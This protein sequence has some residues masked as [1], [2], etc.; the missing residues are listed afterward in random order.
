MSVGCSTAV[1]ELLICCYAVCFYSLL[2]TTLL[3]VDTCLTS[4]MQLIQLQLSSLADCAV[5]TTSDTPDW[6]CTVLTGQTWQHEGIVLQAITCLRGC[7]YTSP[8]AELGQLV[9]APAAATKLSALLTKAANCQALLPD[10]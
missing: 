8:V 5:K 3:V 4:C 6:Y 7:V 9:S 2:H 10:V 1:H